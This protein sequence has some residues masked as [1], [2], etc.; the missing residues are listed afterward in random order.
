ML[1]LA[2]TDVPKGLSEDA[3]PEGLHG[4]VLFK[5]AEGEGTFTV[6]G[7]PGTIVEG[8]EKHVALMLNGTAE[9]GLGR[10]MIE[11]I[12]LSMPHR[13]PVQVPKGDPLFSSFAVNLTGPAYPKVEEIVTRPETVSWVED[14]KETASGT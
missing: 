2:P 5:N 12:Q 10:Y 8:G 14:A 4:D 13:A 9:G 1:R 7:G 3:A 11:R 6:A